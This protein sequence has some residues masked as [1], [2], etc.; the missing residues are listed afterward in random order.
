M[1]AKFDTPVTH[2]NNRDKGTYTWVSKDTHLFLIDRFKA[3]R[4]II[5]FPAITKVGLQRLFDRTETGLVRA[6][7]GGMVEANVANLNELDLLGYHHSRRAESNVYELVKN[8]GL[9]RDL[10]VTA[11]YSK[12]MGRGHSLHLINQFYSVNES[13]RQSQ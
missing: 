5:F 7:L 13:R 12:D 11:D 2:T 9:T 3:E 8:L 1:N 10:S 6:V 4:P